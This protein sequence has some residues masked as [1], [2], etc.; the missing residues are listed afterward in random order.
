M[1]E[2]GT[3]TNTSDY[4][5]D[6][7]SQTYTW[8][9]VDEL[10]WTGDCGIGY[11][12][13][14][15]DYYWIGG[16]GNWSDYS[17]HWS[18]TSGGSADQTAYPTSTSNVY[19]D[20]NSDVGNTAFTVT[21]D[22]N[23]EAKNFNYDSDYTTFSTSTSKTLSAT[24]LY[25]TGGN[26][27]IDNVNTTVS[28][29]SDVDAKLTLN[30]ATYN[31]DGTFDATGGT[32]DFTGSGTL[33]LSSTVTSLGSLDD[34]E[35]TVEYDGTTQTVLSDSYNNLTISTAGIKTVSDSIDVN[36]NLVTAATATCKLDLS[37]YD[38][39]VA[40]DI[41]IG[42]TDGL[43]ASNASCTVTLDGSSNQ[44]ISHAGITQASA[45]ATLYL[46]SSGG[47]YPGEKWLSVTTGVN[48]TGTTLWAQGNGTIGNSSG[49]I[50]DQSL[51]VTKG[52]TYYINAFDQYDDTWDG[53]SWYLHTATSLSGTQVAT[54]SNPSD[55]ADTDASVSWDASEQSLKIVQ[56]L[57]ILQPQVLPCL[58]I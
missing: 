44:N 22:V 52:T 2:S 32:I 56:V 34:S 58:M 42:A 49:L 48:N 30:T 53:S 51:T 6:G 21:M 43:N 29:T 8:V 47:S 15:G 17:N 18:T 50:T 38:L 24:N 13:S 3:P 27:T 16:T 25:V 35:G 28:T 11:A 10:L 26:L 36:G 41:T 20:A 1:V 33:T 39:N 46:T 7:L 57:P 12:L 54:L 5:G 37:T 40:G 14:S 19:F 31:D 9:D 4:S 45:T 23:G 55:G